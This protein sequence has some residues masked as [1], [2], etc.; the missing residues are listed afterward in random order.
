VWCCGVVVL[1]RRVRSF[2][3]QRFEW[4]SRWTR[5]WIGDFKGLSCK[6]DC[7]CRLVVESVA[8]DANRVRHCLA[9]TPLSRIWS[10]LL[11]LP[12][13]SFELVAI[14]LKHLDS[15][16]QQIARIQGIPFLQRERERERERDL[17]CYL[18]LLSPRFVQESFRKTVAEVV[19][20]RVQATWSDFSKRKSSNSSQTLLMGGS[21]TFGLTTPRRCCQALWEYW[22]DC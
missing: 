1:E 5:G 18:L 14:T 8:C 4:D 10:D 7:C 22:E 19:T 13:A 11:S 12:L 3:C 15:G 6:V 21:K 17:Q 9:H 20:I 2:P 16:V